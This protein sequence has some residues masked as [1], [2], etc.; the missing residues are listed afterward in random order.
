MG[1]LCWDGVGLGGL[2]DDSISH[3]ALLHIKSRPGGKRS[4]EKTVGTRHHNNKKTCRITTIMA[5][6]VG[7]LALGSSVFKVTSTI[8][9]VTSADTITGAKL[10]KGITTGYHSQNL[11]GDGQW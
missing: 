3:T 7:N 8:F 9:K 10:Q 5:S 6:T 2:V 11:D 4:E 1:V